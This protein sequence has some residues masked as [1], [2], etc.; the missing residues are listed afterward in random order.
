MLTLVFSRSDGPDNA[1]DVALIPLAP[2]GLYWLA[3]RKLPREADRAPVVAAYHVPDDLGGTVRH[4]LRWQIPFFLLL[5]ALAV[6]S[7]IGVSVG[8]SMGIGLAIVA[9]GISNHV[10]EWEVRSH[11]LL[12]RERRFSLRQ[13]LYVRIPLEQETPT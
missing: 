6:D 1:L 8:L 13:P 12:Y 2:L 5:T 4:E 11:T 7:G 10:G 3:R 9:R